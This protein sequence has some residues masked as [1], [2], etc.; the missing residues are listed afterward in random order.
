MSSGPPLIRS[1]LPVAVSTTDGSTGRSQRSEKKFRNR[2][3][4]CHASAESGLSSYFAF[5]YPE[6]IRWVLKNMASTLNVAPTH[7]MAL[8]FRSCSMMS[9]MRVL[10]ETASGWCHNSGPDTGVGLLWFLKSNA[11]MGPGPVV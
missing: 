11:K 2:V 3:W 8:G 1:A 7:S 4:L 6:P 10:A 9:R 5:S